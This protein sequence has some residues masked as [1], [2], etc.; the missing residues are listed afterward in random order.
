MTREDFRVEP[1]DIVAVERQARALQ[2]QALAEMTSVAW[3]WIV[4]R[5]RRAPAGQTA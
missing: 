2:A 5:L 4:A 1:V 3:G